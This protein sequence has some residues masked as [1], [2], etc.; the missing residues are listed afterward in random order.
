MQKHARHKQVNTTAIYYRPVNQYA[1]HPLRK[2]LE[3]DRE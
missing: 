1:A 2:A 3:K